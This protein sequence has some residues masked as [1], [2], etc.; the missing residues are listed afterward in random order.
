MDAV[1][2]AA[3]LTPDPRRQQR[4]EALAGGAIGVLSRCR[5]SDLASLVAGLR[6]PPGTAAAGLPT[7]VV[8]GEAKR[9]K[10]SLINALL[11]RPGL[12]PVD[13]D[14]ATST[15]IVFRYAG[16]EQARI[17]LAGDE[18]PRAVPL[19]ELADWTTVEGNPANLRNVA[20][21]EVGIDEPL[22]RRVTLV[23]TPGVGG[24]E[25]GHAEGT[26]RALA[27]ADAL[28][29]TVDASA[30]LTIAE[31]HFL[32][33]AS[34]RI[35]TVIIA[36]TKTDLFRGWNRIEQDDRLLLEMHARRFARAPILAVSSTV[37]QKAG[38]IADPAL[39]AE[40]RR[41]SGLDSLHAALR[42]E[43][44]QRAGTLR[45]ANRVRALRQVLE[46]A[47]RSV[48]DLVNAADG[49]P[50]ALA[51]IEGSKTRWGQLSRQRAE[52][53][54]QIDTEIKRINADRSDQ[55]AAGMARIRNRYTE[56]AGTL[57]GAELEALP[58]QL[59]AE[60][61]A[62]AD[63]LNEK[64]QERLTGVVER[65]LGDAESQAS[66]ASVIRELAISAHREEG[67]LPLLS[68][69]ID[70]TQDKIMAL[71][72]MSTGHAAL[73]YT[74]GSIWGGP[75]MIIPGLALGM[76]TALVDRKSRARQA[77]QTAVKTWIAQQLGDAQAYL[78]SQFNLRMIE[79]T[80]RLGDAIRDYA[81]QREKELEEALD[82]QRRIAAQDRETRRLRKQ[83]LSQELARLRDLQ[84]GAEEL[85]TSLRGGRASAPE[86]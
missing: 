10:S 15:Y 74:L 40:L 86:G 84:R 38:A 34:E 61:S 81:E 70:S 42:G 43:V 60:L 71:S 69:R 68:G 13:M 55:L 76:L 25:A 54:R 67:V 1:S 85:L 29:F 14:V 31:L 27:G 28:L 44:V 65:I 3:T 50:A 17:H 4:L 35:E 75:I 11:G 2:D 30:P 57:D 83:E 80:E 22:L 48:V 45:L 5:R 16:Q 23:D 79:V 49:D 19:D 56:M 33:R 20:W 82:E 21:A 36:L 64:S 8:V 51:A 24:L 46:Q 37:A 18:P 47:D 63:S 6:E 39:S 78:N 53:S 58:Q 7:V 62:F 52:W 26:L 72:R 77:K 66:L 73:S 9:G 59:L 12:A 41:E 32:Q